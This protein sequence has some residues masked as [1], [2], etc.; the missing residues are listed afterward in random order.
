MPLAKMI[1]EKPSETEG[2]FLMCNFMILCS[3]N[4][5][6]VEELLAEKEQYVYGPQYNSAGHK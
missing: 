1:I 3:E 2:F 4:I 5:D 6:Y